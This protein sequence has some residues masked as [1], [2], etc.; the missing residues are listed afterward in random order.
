MLKRP[1]IALALTLA[2][3]GPLAV[4]GCGEGPAEKVG[5]RIDGNASGVK[6]KLTPDGAAEKA[7]KDLDRAV[8]DATD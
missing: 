4:I 2:V 6:D 3:T 7:G 1:A 5:E 8:D